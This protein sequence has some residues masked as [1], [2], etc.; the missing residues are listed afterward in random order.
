MT[1]PLIRREDVTYLW[2]SGYYDGPLSGACEWRGRRYWFVCVDEEYRPV[3]GPDGNRVL[4][5]YGDPELDDVRVFHLV[6]LTPEEWAAVDAS[7]ALFR[8]CVGTHTD[9]DRVT[10]RRNTSG[11]VRPEAE[12]KRYYDAHPPH[13]VSPRPEAA[14][15][16]RPAVAKY[17]A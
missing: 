14:W 5:E 12:W 17:E 11:T 1:A 9:Y 13:N 8:E 2:H 7:H 4:D 10:Q 16:T 6:E 3:V 15:A